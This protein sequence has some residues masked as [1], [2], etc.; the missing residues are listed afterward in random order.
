MADGR[1]VF[2]GKAGGDEGDYDAASKFFESALGDWGRTGSEGGVAGALVDLGALA[3]AEGDYAAAE[4]LLQEGLHRKPRTRNDPEEDSLWAGRVQL[5]LA[6]CS[7]ARG[8]L[9][10][11]MSWIMEGL[12][13]TR[14][15]NNKAQVSA[16]VEQLAHVG[17]ALGSWGAA[18]RLLGGADRIRLAI[19]PIRPQGQATRDGALRHALR[20]AGPST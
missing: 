4:P 9:G 11:A 8:D 6:E 12:D 7:K 20:P 2:L 10:Q 16:L 14:H 3:C 19:G 18:I 13:E 5:G 17:W 1:L 15:S